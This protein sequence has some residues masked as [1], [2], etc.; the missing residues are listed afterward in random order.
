M[1]TVNKM[2][3]SDT[4]EVPTVQGKTVTNEVE[5]L[6]PTVVPPSEKFN[7][8]VSDSVKGCIPS[9]ERF[10]E[11]APSPSERKNEVADS[12]GKNEVA[13]SEGKNEVAPPERNECA[14]APNAE[15]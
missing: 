6:V 5:V 8:S 9:S 10:T 11:P 14:P 15:K 13:D 1:K 12:E 4:K 3:D 2:N 7:E